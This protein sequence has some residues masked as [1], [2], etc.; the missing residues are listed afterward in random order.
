MRNNH[1]FISSIAFLFIKLQFSSQHYTI[2]VY[3]LTCGRFYQDRGSPQKLSPPL[4]VL[5]G[6]GDT[7][8]NK[9]YS[10]PRPSRRSCGARYK[11]VS[12]SDGLSG[13][14]TPR[15]WMLAN[16]QGLCR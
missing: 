5:S 11:S 10:S 16:L 12:P 4:P 13:L 8:W 3:S 7:C 14:A 6:I 15:K 2:E 9:P 1:H